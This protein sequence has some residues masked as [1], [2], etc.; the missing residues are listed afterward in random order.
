MTPVATTTSPGF[1]DGQRPPATPKLMTPRIVDGSNVARSARNC[2]GSLLLQITVMPG[3]AAMRASC[4][5][6]VT[7]KI[8]RGSNEVPTD[9]AVPAPKFTFRPLPPCCW[10]SSNFDT[11]PAPRAERTSSSHDSADKTPEE[12]PLPC[13]AAH[14]TGL[15]RSVCL[16]GTPP[17]AR[18]PDVQPRPPPLIQARTMPFVRR[19]WAP[20]DMPYSR[21]G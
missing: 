2:F 17:H 21:V 16:L 18:P 3:P 19:S 15:F 13:N 20:A 14:P 5:R 9:A 8:G 11:A 12:T 7:I 10:C 6:P 1:S 4:T